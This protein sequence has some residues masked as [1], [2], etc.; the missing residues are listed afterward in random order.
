MAFE[1]TP[2]SL[3]NMSGWFFESESFKVDENA[4]QK[5][6]ETFPPKEKAV[7]ASQAEFKILASL[8]Y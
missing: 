8:I 2:G 1:L 3:G 6:E 5:Y 7:T 4:F